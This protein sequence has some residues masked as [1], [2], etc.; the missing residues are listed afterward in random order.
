[1]DGSFVLP[2]DLLHLPFRI[3]MPFRRNKI[4]CID[5]KTRIQHLDISETSWKVS[6]SSAK[7]K[8]LPLQNRTCVHITH[9]WTNSC[10]PKLK[11]SGSQVW[12]SEFNSQSDKSQTNV[13][14]WRV[15]GHRVDPIDR[16][17]QR[18]CVPIGQ[19]P[20]TRKV[21]PLSDKGLY[22]VGANF[23]QLSRKYKPQ[24]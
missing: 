3:K 8:R 2:L 9:R 10:S 21:L 6:P 11:S 4:R 20:T 12:T 16:L 19:V 23:G 13:E 22:K 14:G 5:L 17:T 15:A 1:M 18:G 24:L 7:R